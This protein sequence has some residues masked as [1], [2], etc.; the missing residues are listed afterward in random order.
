MK[1]LTILFVACLCMV[2][3]C[4]SEETGYNFDA[5][6]VKPAAD[7]TDSRDGKVYSCIQIGEQVW[8]TENLSY[9]LPKGTLD[10]CFSWDGETF[11]MSD[12]SYSK[13]DWVEL[14]ETTLNDPAYDWAAMGVQVSLVNFYVSMVKRGMMYAS[15]ATSLLETNAP[16]FY[17]V[18]KDGLEELKEP[19]IAQMA[20]ENFQETEAKNG[21]YSKT[22]GLLYSY[23]AAQ[24]AVP[25][26]WRLPTDD[27][28]KKLE[29]TLGMSRQEI[30]KLNEW[31]GAGAGTLLK[32]EGVTGFNARMAGGDVYYA[33]NISPKFLRCGESCYF[34]TSTK[35]KQNDS[36]DLAVIR[37]L[38]VYSD[39]VWRG[40]SR[41]DNGK[42]DMHYSVRCVKDVQ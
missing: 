35:T 5:S 30:D 25:E 16:A 32:E 37:S 7:F 40:T 18:V 29:E 1:K 17:E 42:R 4:D 15:G 3:A 31:R 22:Y 24:K 27:D 10:G 41:I 19:A 12:V 8:M 36:I 26:G 14:M 21:N 9:L 23:E 20:L 38:A 11:D 34:W 6:L 28:W 2:W 33:S 39:A 13:D